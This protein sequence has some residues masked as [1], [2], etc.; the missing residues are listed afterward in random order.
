MDRTLISDLRQHAGQAVA[1]QGWLQTLRDQKKM[2]FLVVRD[3]SGTAQV[4]FEKNTDA[5]LAALISS[6]TPESVV[7]I[8]GTVLANP[9]VKLGGLEIQL[10]SLRV[11]SLAAAPLPLDPSAGDL[12]ALDYRLDWRFLDLR[13]TENLL[14]F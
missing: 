1:I 13:R 5:G 12:P 4:V 6:T 14:M 10:E 8:H 7:T 11:D 3:A 2:Q 9:V